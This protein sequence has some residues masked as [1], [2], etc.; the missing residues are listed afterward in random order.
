MLDRQIA[1]RATGSGSSAQVIKVD[2]N[3]CLGSCGP[4]L[5]LVWRRESTRSAV[6]DAMRAVQALRALHPGGLGIIVVVEPT[7]AP[8]SGEIRRALAE[9]LGS[10]GP[11]VKRSALVHEG[12]G[13]RAAAV[14]AV[15]TGLS[16]IAQQPYPHQVF[17]SVD[18]AATWV[19]Q[20]LPR[21]ATSAEE[22]REAIGALR[23]HQVTT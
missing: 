21:E 6:M 14:R 22:L 10:L 4:V 7:A 18:L 8:P 9:T 20:G 13:F 15:V 17:D 1:R 23:G 19:M 11:V 12:T 16:A 5:V 3:H 2:T